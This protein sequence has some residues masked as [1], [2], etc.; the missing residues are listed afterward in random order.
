MEEPKPERPISKIKPPFDW[1]LI[2]KVEGLV[3]ASML[4]AV[5]FFALRIMDTTYSVLL[6]NNSAVD[7]VQNIFSARNLAVQQHVE[8]TVSS[9]PATGNDPFGYV[10]QTGKKTWYQFFLPRGVS[11]VGSVTFETTGTP[12]NA[13]SFV[14]SKGSRAVS[15]DIDEKGRASTTNI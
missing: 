9:T 2:R 4:I 10:V 8:I 12:Q 3:F 11:M 1:R 15:V 7:L 14:I 6:I 13:T 5:P